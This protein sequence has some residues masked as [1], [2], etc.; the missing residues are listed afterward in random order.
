MHTIDIPD[1]WAMAAADNA[2]RDP[3]NHHRPVLAARSLSILLDLGMSEA[4]IARYF[5]VSERRI[6]SLRRYFGLT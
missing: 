2:P 3:V 1:V 6:A 5:K 4:Q